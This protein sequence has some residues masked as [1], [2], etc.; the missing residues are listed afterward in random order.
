MYLCEYL[1]GS[2]VTGFDGSNELVTICTIATT[3]VQSFD[4]DLIMC[5]CSVPL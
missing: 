5:L 3:L 4:M 2:Y 1:V